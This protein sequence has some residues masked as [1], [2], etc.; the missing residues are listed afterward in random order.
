[1]T[2]RPTRIP[3][4]LDSEGRFT[5]MVLPGVTLLPVQSIAG[6]MTKMA[7][8]PEFDG[9]STDRDCGARSPAT[10]AFSNSQ[11]TQTA[12]LSEGRPGADEYRMVATLTSY[13]TSL[14][15]HRG[16]QAFE[17]DS[18]TCL[19]P[20]RG[21]QSA[22]TPH[23]N[24]EAFLTYRIESQ[25]RPPAG[26]HP[27]S[28]EVVSTWRSDRLLLIIDIAVPAYA[29]PRRCSEHAPL[30]PWLFAL[31][32]RR[33]TRS[34]NPP[35][36]DRRR[37]CPPRTAQV[38]TPGHCM[39]RATVESRRHARDDVM[40]A[41][42]RTP[43]ARRDAGPRCRRTCPARSPSWCRW[44]ARGRSSHLPQAT[45]QPHCTL[46]TSM[47]CAGSTARSRR[48]AIRSHSA[49][50]SSPRKVNAETRGSSRARTAPT[51][52]KA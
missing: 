48:P 4:L 25:D 29:A 28:V 13:R 24:G 45:N 36:S 19:I 50:S 11:Y 5:R 33:R 22:P 41:G 7:T 42:Q 21:F 14:A 49:S 46:R 40:V 12:E 18:Q 30:L 32:C 15:A 23:P 6:A 44:S 34:G 2:P 37:G 9:L 27:G 26:H 39:P 35:S 51:V 3:P 31:S 8:T 10:D 52:S 43:G 47:I 20:A 38:G 1:M 17:H 16:Y